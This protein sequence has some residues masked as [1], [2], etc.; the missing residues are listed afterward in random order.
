[1]IVILVVVGY[2]VLNRMYNN[3]SSIQVFST[4]EEC[5]KT[6]GAICRLQLCDYK[7]PRDFKTGWTKVEVE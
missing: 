7:C 3:S 1:M 2:F 4:Q 6:T 5:Q